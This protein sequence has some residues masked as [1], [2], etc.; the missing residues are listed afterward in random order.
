[1][2][3]YLHISLV[4]GLEREINDQFIMSLGFQRDKDNSQKFI[5]HDYSIEVFERCSQHKTILW[6][7]SGGKNRDFK[8]GCGKL[9]KIYL[10]FADLSGCKWDKEYCDKITE[11][12]RQKVASLQEFPVVGSSKSFS[13]NLE[14][15]EKLHFMIGNCKA[16][17]F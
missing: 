3:Y 6:L 1:M 11:R 7:E 15:M 16:I 17:S 10:D 4:V 13:V 12:L 2:D 8:S 5:S 14:M 9:L